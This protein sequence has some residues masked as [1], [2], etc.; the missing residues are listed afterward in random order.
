MTTAQLPEV[1]SVYGMALDVLA[2]SSPRP[3]RSLSSTYHDDTW[4][5]LSGWESI[6]EHSYPYPSG[7]TRIGVTVRS[8]HPIAPQL[9]V[10]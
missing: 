1:I 9:A 2:H 3:L 10:V 8:R 7:E 6:G 4:S 5:R